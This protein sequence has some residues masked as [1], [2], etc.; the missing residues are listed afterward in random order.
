MNIEIYA[1][2]HQEEKMIGYFMR[3]YSQYGIVH[4][5]EG[6]STDRTV[7]IAKSMGAVIIPFNTNNEIREDLFT[8]MKNNCWKQSKADWVII[9]DIDEFVYHPNFKEYLSTLD[10]TVIVPQSYD[11]FSDDF[12][13]TTG[14]IYEDVTMGVKYNYKTNCKSCI[15][16]PQQI[17]DINYKPGAHIADPQGNI[18]TNY[19]SEIIYMHMHNLGIDHVVTKNAYYSKRRSLINKKMGWGYHVDASAN[20]VVKIFDTWKPSLIKVL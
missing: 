14:Q 9:V 4:L 15:F 19:D 11:M 6:H 2:A 5:F 16:K 10:D 13:T 8:D 1:L 20:D 7:E 17:T 18:K 12:P 3:H